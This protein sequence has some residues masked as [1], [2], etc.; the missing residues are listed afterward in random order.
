MFVGDVRDA[1]TGIGSLLEVVRREP[2][3]VRGDE[4]L[5]VPPVARR[6]AQRRRALVGVEN[7]VAPSERAR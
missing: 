1:T 7:E 6:V 2:V 5:E 4:A 3:R